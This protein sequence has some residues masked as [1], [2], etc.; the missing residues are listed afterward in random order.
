MTNNCRKTTAP[1]DLNSVCYRVIFKE[2]ENRIK[3]KSA[4]SIGGKESIKLDG[5]S[6]FLTP[7]HISF[8][9]SQVNIMH[10]YTETESKYTG[11]IG[12]ETMTNNCRKPQPR[13]T[14]TRVCYDVCIK[15]KMWTIRKCPGILLF[16][17]ML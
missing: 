2:V 3:Y 12:E 10:K 1:S 16:P 11:K 15:E 9:I 13:V 14:S 8:F 6:L 4:K 17:P 7:P 5:C